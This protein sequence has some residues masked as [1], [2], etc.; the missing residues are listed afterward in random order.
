MHEH[1]T[2]NRRPVRST[3]TGR[4][5]FGAGLVLEALAVT[6]LVSWWAHAPSDAAASPL[7]APAAIAGAPAHVD[8]PAIGV[9]ADVE[10]LGLRPS[11]AVEVP[12]SY[13]R[14]GWY[15]GSEIPGGPGPTVVLGHIDSHTR[16]AVFFRLSKLRAGDEV[17]VERADSAVVR[18]VV[19]RIGQFRKSRFP[20]AA[21]YGPTPAPTLRLLTCAGPFHGH[22]RD[23]L[24]VFAR[25][26]P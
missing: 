25:L 7:R 22:Y 5:L 17:V 6:A 8:I 16:P 12:S 19:D 13:D 11:G 2:R 3:R 21:V 15:A 18:F 20:T 14:V 1:D 4:L 24:V 26:A 9:S 10:T 23:N